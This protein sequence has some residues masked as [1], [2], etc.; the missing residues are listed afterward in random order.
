MPTDSP[1]RAIACVR[2]LPRR[3]RYPDLEIV[4]VTNSKLLESLKN[5]QA[6]SAVVR[7]VPYDKRFNFSDKCNVGAEAATG[8]RVIF[9]NDDVE[10]VRP[11]WIQNLIEPLENPEV[12]AVSPK[13]LYETGKIQHAGLV[14]GVRGLVGTAFHQRASDSSEHFNL[15]QSLRDVAALS[16]ACLAMRREDFLRLGGFDAV[17]TPIAHSD[18]DLSFKIREAGLRCVYTPYATLTHAGHVSI[19][20]KEEEE[21]EETRRRDKASIYLLKR[22]GHYTTH[23]PYFTDNMRDWLFS[24]SPTPIR[25]MARD[26]P[27]SLES[28]PDL[29]FVSHDLSLS[30]AP[31]LL[32]QLA[33]WCKRN[34]IFVLVVAP[35]DGPVREKYEA[36]GIPLIIDPL[37]MNRHESFVELARDFDCVLANTIQSEPAVQ[38]A[39]AARVPVIWWVHETQVGEHF[40]RADGKL[41]S[42][43]ALAD[44]V[45]APSE[46]TANVYRPFTDLSV[47]RFCYGI[48]D[49]GAS[50]AVSGNGQPRA[51]RFLVLGSIEPRKGQDV[52]LEAVSSLPREM[53]ESAEFHLL[54]R[55]MDL[56]FGERLEAAVAGLASVFL[57]GPCDHEAAL[58]AIRGS[59]VLVCSSRDEAMP[60]TIL[61]ALSL[62]KAIVSTNVGGIGEILT[63]GHDALLVRSEDPPG[64]AA[65]MQRLWESPVLV[66]H[67]GQNARSTFEKHFTQDRFGADF[68]QLVAEVMARDAAHDPY[69]MHDRGVRLSSDGPTPRIPASDQPAGEG[70]SLRLLFVSHDLSLSG[71]PMMLL[72]AAAACQR[73]GV[74]VQVIA[75]KDGP[76][77]ENLRAENIPVIIDPLIETG[78]ESFARFARG[79]DCIIANTIFSAAVVCA[80]KGE[81]VPIVWWVHEPGSIGELY[82]QKDAELRAA[83]PFAGLLLTPSESTAQFYQRYTDRPVKCL[84]NAIPDLGFAGKSAGANTPH[85]LRFLFLGSLESRKGQDVFVE[86]LA[87]LPIELQKAAQFQIAGRILEVDFW[88]KVE[89]VVKTLH[90]VSVR[91]ALSHAEAIE[92]M[93]EADVVVSASRDEAMPTVTILEAM[94]LGKAIIATTVGGAREV[95]VDGENALLVGSE[96]PDALSAAIRRLIE[97]PTLASELGKKARGTYERNFTME[98]F[99]EEFRRLI[100]E[101]ISQLLTVEHAQD[102]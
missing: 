31:I 38:S 94:S 44:V 80:L 19:A 17:N 101:A 75:P 71:A 23:D 62:G 68:R 43:L 56:K 97:D 51:F 65:T 85:Q 9:F 87:F 57:D 48:P 26:E 64:L 16:A 59:D 47:R 70:S 78:H 24:D 69:L 39:F 36:A 35:A 84:R 42:A 2:D 93:R 5:L 52:F 86:A 53:L 20:V 66:Q 58:Q 82:L 46:R 90:H 18:V 102:A 27:A 81:R 25:M 83:M 10:P 89:A 96:A 45:L 29:L 61:E 40:L 12:G 32:L 98:R 30:G 92:L 74:F 100:D 8:A 72:H 28:Y 7:L 77:G 73:D 1:T 21:Q 3:T 54:G 49:V 99:S 55:V 79:F 67:L 11:H 22:W 33:I 14:T 88:P 41:R 15:A 60:V 37:I 91:G 6:Q 95:L 63:D 13:L 4:I 34:G 50:V 76:L